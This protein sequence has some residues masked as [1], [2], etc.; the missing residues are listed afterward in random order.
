MSTRSKVLVESRAGRGDPIPERIVKLDDTALI[1]LIQETHDPDGR[2]IDCQPLMRNIEE[3][4]YRV[5][6]LG[7]QAAMQKT[8]APSDVDNA[9]LATLSFVVNRISSQMTYKCLVNG[10]AHAIAV[11][12]LQLLSAYFWDAK[13]VLLLAAFVLNY[14]E[15]WL[16]IQIHGSSKLASKIATLKQVPKLGILKQQLEALNNLIMLLLDL[17]KCIIEFK[18]LPPESSD[19]PELSTAHGA[20]PTAVYWFTRGIVAC[21]AHSTQFTA[22]NYDYTTLRSGTLEKEL[23]A[24]AD[25]IK[26]SNERLQKQLTICYQAIDEK[27]EIDAYKSLSRLI[28]SAHID[29]MKVLKA[30]LNTNEDM[31]PLIEGY[32]KIRIKIQITQFTLL[33]TSCLDILGQIY[34]ESKTYSGRINDFEFVWIPMVESSPMTEATKQKFENCLAAMPWCS[35]G[36]PSF[37]SKPVKR[38]IREKF[39]YRNKPILVVLDPQGKVSSLNAFHMMWTWGTFGFPFTKQREEALWKEEFWRLELLVNGIDMTILNWIRSGRHIILYGGDD[40][41]WIT[42]FTDTAH[43]VALSG[44]PLELVYVG[45]GD[46]SEQ[47][48]KPLV[49]TITN[50]RLSYCWKEIEIWFFWTR[51]KSMLFS[52]I[53]LKTNDEHDPVMQEIE[54]LL[55]YDGIGTWALF[56]RG[57]DVSFTGRGD[58]VLHTLQKFHEWKENVKRIDFFD[59]LKEQYEQLCGDDHPCCHLDFDNIAG[60][61]PEN[62]MCPDCHRSMEQNAIYSCCHEPVQ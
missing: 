34:M 23:S 8:P 11:S 40:I 61:I 60:E 36:H 53:Q 6:P 7:I 41:Q 14:S 33:N 46:K 42:N 10:D 15:C 56:S 22:S 37:I 48:M 39:H 35:V 59:A 21:A 29:N 28:E 12:L 2:E 1:R 52:K 20:I 9:Q 50:K 24:L 32:T 54:K 27:K 13:L 49:D 44:I 5:A 45:K 38:F 25:K 47:E 30:L 43:R 51:L 62:M 4:L 19:L 17:A 16:V 18:E 55:M 31:A 3:I 57:S 26:I 58:D